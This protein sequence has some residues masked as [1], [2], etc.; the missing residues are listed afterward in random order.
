MFNAIFRRSLSVTVLLLVLGSVPA[1]AAPG[2]RTHSPR[3]PAVTGVPMLDQLLDWLGLRSGG[4]IPSGTHRQQKSGTAATGGSG[5]VDSR[6]RLDRG[7]MI[8][9]N[10]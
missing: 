4:K 2:G 10:G 5:E 3:T 8:D 7:G 9:P 6:T 1:M